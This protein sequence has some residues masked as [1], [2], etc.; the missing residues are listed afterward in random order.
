MAEFMKSVSQKPM[1]EGKE[2]DSGLF[3][4]EAEAKLLA[5]RPDLAAGKKMMQAIMESSIDEMEDVGNIYD[6]VN[7]LPVYG[8][9]AYKG[10]HYLKTPKGEPERVAGYI[11]RL[12]KSLIILSQKLKESQEQAVKLNV[13][14]LEAKKPKKRTRRKSK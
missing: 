7:K 2:Y 9:Y 14:L 8:V 1:T 4:R 12:E 13:E 5:E 11:N 10:E 6:G 3:D